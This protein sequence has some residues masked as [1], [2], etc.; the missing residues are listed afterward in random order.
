MMSDIN[1]ITLRN[2]SLRTVCNG[3]KSDSRAGETEIEALK[4][5][6]AEQACRKRRVRAQNS[7]VFINDSEKK[8][9]I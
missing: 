4:I 7:L 1:K 8:K 6:R 9:K 2:W 3:S 5:E